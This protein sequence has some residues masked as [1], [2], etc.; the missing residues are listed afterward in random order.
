MPYWCLD[1]SGNDSKLYL[2]DQTSSQTKHPRVGL[3]P[4]LINKKISHCPLALVTSWHRE[5]RVMLHGFRFSG[6]SVSFLLPF[7]VSLLKSVTELETSWPNGKVT[8]LTASPNYW[9]GEGLSLHSLL[10]VPICPG[11]EITFPAVFC[12]N[13][14]ASRYMGTTNE[15]LVIVSVE[16][17]CYRETDDQKGRQVLG[18]WS[19][20]DWV[21][22]TGQSSALE[23]L[24]KN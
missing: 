8:Q 1:N 22:F 15:C 9:T 23:Q 11:A 14:W 21:L 17:I 12:P 10:V 19:G 24:S 6:R 7:Q 18:V 3:W 4:F 13:P 2:T 5:G 16:A 20:C